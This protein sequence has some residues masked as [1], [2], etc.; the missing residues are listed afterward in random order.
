VSSHTV[1]LA[2]AVTNDLLDLSFLFKIIESLSRK[3]S[4][5][6]QTVDED[7]NR[8][9]TVGLD[10]LGELVRGGLVE[11]DCVV[12]LVLDCRVKWSAGNSSGSRIAPMIV[13]DEMGVVD[14][15][16]CC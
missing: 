16:R 9:E 11:D 15:Y 13:M 8:N 7:C 3:R 14:M 10:I 4:V 12:C 2:P 5:D 6:L 1:D